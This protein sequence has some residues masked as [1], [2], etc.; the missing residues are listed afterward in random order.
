MSAVLS[1][2]QHTRANYSCVGQTAISSRQ[3]SSI[4]GWQK[5]RSKGA[6]NLAPYFIFPLLSPFVLPCV[7]AAREDGRARW[8]FSPAVARRR[9]SVKTKAPPKQSCLCP[10]GGAPWNSTSRLNERHG[11]MWMV[12]SVGAA[13][14]QRATG[15]PSRRQAECTAGRG[16]VPPAGG[17]HRP[18]GECIARRVKMCRV[19]N[20]NCVRTSGFR[21]IIAA[22]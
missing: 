16:S 10:A 21:R 8:G 12:V 11:P 19:K 2:V 14:G 13:A 15:R 5:V 4:P 9:Q 17:V 6:I 20:T 7:F 18:P 22:R 1:R 3:S